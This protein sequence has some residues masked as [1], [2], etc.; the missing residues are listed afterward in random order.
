MAI[1]KVIIGNTPYYKATYEK[2]FLLSVVSAL[3]VLK[4]EPSFSLTGGYFPSGISNATITIFYPDKTKETFNDNRGVDEIVKKVNLK[5][6]TYR[7]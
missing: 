2:D 4:L 6:G 3:K 7:I 5:E 1:D